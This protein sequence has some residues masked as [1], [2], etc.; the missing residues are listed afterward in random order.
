[1]C[2][3]GNVINLFREENK[4]AKKF[5]AKLAERKGNFSRDRS[6]DAR[7]K[8]QHDRAIAEVC[9]GSHV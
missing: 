7:G 8:F 5:V 2:G 4:R 1:V 9:S 6:R 3:Q